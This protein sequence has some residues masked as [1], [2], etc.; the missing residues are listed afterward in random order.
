MSVPR[1]TPPGPT[2]RPF[3]RSA[4]VCAAWAAAQASAAAGP[5]LVLDAGSLFPAPTRI[6]GG[7]STVSS[8]G[9]AKGDV[10]KPFASRAECEARCQV[11]PG[12]TSF[13]F[14][15]AEGGCGAGCGAYVK[16]H[17]REARARGPAAAR[18]GASLL[19]RLLRCPAAAA[20]GVLRRAAARPSKAWSVSTRG[21]GQG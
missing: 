20:E 13:A 21:T 2:R 5:L 17:P 15:E 16:Q 12:C 18:E 6:Y 3:H 9:P 1:P 7:G 8:I 10:K 11:L 19:R 14:C 4:A